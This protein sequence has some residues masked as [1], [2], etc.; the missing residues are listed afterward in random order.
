MTGELR[1]AEPA[2]LLVGQLF[3]GGWSVV[4]LQPLVLEQ[5]VPAEL[6]RRVVVPLGPL[7]L[8]AFVIALSWQSHFGI[9]LAAWPV[10]FALLA[11][12]LLGVLN[13]IR[14]VRRQREGVRLAIDA[15]TVTGYPEARTW[16]SDYFVRLQQHPRAAV[17]GASLTVYRDPKRGTSARAKV[18]LELE[19]GGALVGPEASGEDAQWTQVRDALLPA[20]AAIARAVGKKLVLDYPTMNERVEVS[21]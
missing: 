10:G 6:L 17:K 11:I 18:R 15:A 4:T 14:S 19:G 8:G 5:R 12:A 1:P 7:L 9:K 21:W 2:Q 16:L 13:L 20:A 3:P